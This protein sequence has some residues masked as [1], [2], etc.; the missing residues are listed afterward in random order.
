MPRKVRAERENNIRLS[1]VVARLHVFAKGQLRARANAVTVGRIKLVPLRLWVVA[2]DLRK[3]LRQ[4]RGS[5]RFGED[6][7]PC[8]VAETTERLGERP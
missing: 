7:Q 4:H 1:E 2:Q 8:P 3:L 5:H 6:M